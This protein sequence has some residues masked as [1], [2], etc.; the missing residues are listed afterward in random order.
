[1]SGPITRIDGIYD[2][3]TLSFLSSRGVA[4]FGFD[5]RPL[6]LNFLQ[7]HVFF[8]ILD[9]LINSNHHYYLRYANE[10]AFVTEKMLTDLRERFGETS[11]KK[12]FTLE[13]S[14]DRDADF[15]NQ[16][17]MPFIWR[18][19]SME[20]LDKLLSLENLVGVVVDHSDLEGYQ[21]NGRLFDFLK[22]LYGKVGERKVI[23]NL[24]WNS[25]LISSVLDFYP[26][27]TLKVAIDNSVELSYRQVDQNRLGHQL[28]FLQTKIYNVCNR[29][30]KGSIESTDG[31]NN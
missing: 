25:S 2:L 12:Y 19:S 27:D 10:P 9:E 24:K 7:Q 31:M 16:F 5:F 30:G 18:F 28:N 22:E 3:S 23:L 13:F 17:D 21:D 4:E 6:S 26:V 14:D 20:Q 29:S 15:Y 1:M 8:E 11:V